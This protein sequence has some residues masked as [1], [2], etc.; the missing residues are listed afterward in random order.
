MEYVPFKPFPFLFALNR[1]HHKEFE[2]NFVASLTM[3]EA[4]QA[5]GR[6]LHNMIGGILTGMKHFID[7]RLELTSS[8]CG[9]ILFSLFFFKSSMCS[10]PLICFS[11]GNHLH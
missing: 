9:L 5:L 2:V 6:C 8:A 3:C 11:L 4:L 1:L 7:F 10:S